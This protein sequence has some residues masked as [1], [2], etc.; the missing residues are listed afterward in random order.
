M[1]LILL[2]SNY[3]LYSNQKLLSSATH[4]G[5]DISFINVAECYLTINS[6]N[7][8]IY[9]QN[10]KIHN[11][12]CVITRIKPALTYYATSIIR[13]FEATNITCLNSSNAIINSRNKLYT[14][15]ILAQNNLPVPTTA[16][17]NSASYT[18]E[19][20]EKV[21]QAPLIIKL[22]EGT[23]GV[24]VMLAETN[25]AAESI[26][27]SF[28]SLKNDVLVQQY[29]HEAKGQDIRCFVIGDKVIATMQRT[30]QEGEFRA[31]IHLGAS[32]KMIKITPQEEEI[33]IK[34]TKLLGLQIAGVDMVRS[35]DGLKI[36]EVNSSPGLEGIE[37]AT[38]LDIGKEIISH[39]ISVI[40]KS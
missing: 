22:I 20:V 7:L 37:K 14:L 23:K 32:G 1:K 29:V 28:Y 13:Q 4:L 9:H 17:A 5:H 11:I 16:F 10:N 33:A 18:K 30:A 38:Q 40:K 15:Q 6:K 39:I 3:K 35:A 21:N 25:K 8:E 36:L 34:S 31:N 2:A 27:N 19:L 12:D 26:I 24:G